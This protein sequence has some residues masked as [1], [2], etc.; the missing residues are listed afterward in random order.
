MKAKY[1]LLL[2]A[3]WF[4]IASFSQILVRENVIW[5]S[6]IFEGPES[7]PFYT[8]HT[9]FEGDTMIQSVTYKKIYR[10]NNEMATN[11][12]L[13]C[14][15]IREKDGK[16]FVYNGGLGNEYLYYDFNLSE[17]DSFYIYWQH[18]PEDDPFIVD[19]IRAKEIHGKSYKHWYLSWGGHQEVW[20]EK[21]GSLY[22]V[23][24]SIGSF[25]SGGYYELLCVSENGELIYQNE[26]YNTCFMKSNEVNV[27]ENPPPFLNVLPVSG[28]ELLLQL[29]PGDVGNFFLYTPNG[30]RILKC[31]LTAPET[32]L[33]APGRGLYLY[34]FVSE[35]GG[36]QSGKVVVE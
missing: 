24:L 30:K 21:I 5:S 33:C 7:L 1:I 6:V 9:K 32:T 22:D 29:S 25:M 16:V 34:R 14:E 2:F 23:L 36:V 3:Q 11:W 28:E 4:S 20:I 19:S 35:K 26:Q 10:S 17:G 15:F 18:P 8:H 13:W 12:S 31:P 27:F